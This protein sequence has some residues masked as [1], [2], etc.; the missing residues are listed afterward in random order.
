M[1]QG[2]HLLVPFAAC[3]AAGCRQRL[4]SLALPQLSALLA[5]MA[6]VAEDA[7]SPHDLS[8]PHERVLARAAGLWPGDGRVPGAAWQLRRQG[9]DPGEAAW[10]WITPC[11][12]AVG[13]DHIR[14]QPPEA[15]S[16]AEDE[17]R[18]LLAAMQPY[19]EEDGL[20]L[21]YE[22]PTRWLARGEPLR[23]LACASLDRVSGSV[24]DEWLPRAP[25]ARPLR[26]L[27]QEM[28]MLLYTHAVNEARE[29]RGLPPVNSFWVSGAGALAAGATPAEPAMQLQDA[30]RAPALA[31]DWEAWAQ[32]WQTLDATV[33]A[34]LRA[35]LERG[36]P[37]TL[38]LCGDAIARRWAPAPRGLWQRLSG[39][40]R[41][42]PPAAR[43][44]DTL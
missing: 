10:A 7:G 32:A 15:L 33:L 39:L 3:D 9:E 12:W 37:L 11:H 24:V 31:G 2:V 28:Q 18:A 17:S 14:M 35:A 23:A 40:W 41:A 34:P 6:P 27:Q 19:F 8:M 16:L 42:A 4:R 29:A 13:Q 38:T 25:E 26:R 44:L 20:A 22:Q 30:L 36:E 21:R 5:R 1:S 43:E